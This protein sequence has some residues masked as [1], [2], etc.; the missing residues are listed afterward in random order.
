M[1]LDSLTQYADISQHGQ[2]K[3]HNDTNGE[4]AYVDAGVW[5]QPAQNNL[6]NLILADV[7]NASIDVKAKD[8]PNQAT[9]GS[10]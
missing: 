3:L 8:D 9:C 10:Q 6:R 2:D 1:A 4:H 5:V 7:D